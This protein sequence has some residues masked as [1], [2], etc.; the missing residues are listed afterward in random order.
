MTYKGIIQNLDE[1]EVARVPL[2]EGMVALVDVADLHL[3][4]RFSWRALRG[5]NSKYYAYAKQGDTGYYMHRLIAS[6]PAG[7]ETDHING[8]GLDNQ[9]AN[10]RLATSS[11]NSANTGKPAP[12]NGRQ[13]TSRFKGVSWSSHRSCWVAHIM[14]DKKSKN[15][16]GFPTED[17][18]ATA[19]DIAALAS[20]GEFAYL[21]T[22]K[23]A[24]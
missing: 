4:A 15:L 23:E 20:W 19:Y 24:S 2:G 1:T 14:V 5:H 6:T 10:L 18:A 3:V 12:A 16:G 13:H 8:D 11:Q 21:N 17:A 9:R 22:T 7:M